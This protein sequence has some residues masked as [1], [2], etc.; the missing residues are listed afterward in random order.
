MPQS[1]NGEGGNNKSLATQQ[2]LKVAIKSIC[3]IMRR[4]NCAGALRYVPKLTWILFLRILDEH[5]MREKVDRR[6]PLTLTDFEE[7]FH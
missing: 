3:N 4:S 5:E 6:N 7:F 2:S 1:H